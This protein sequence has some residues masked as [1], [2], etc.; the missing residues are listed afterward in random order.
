VLRN[1]N[2]LFVT[3]HSKPDF[4]YG[5]V[6]ESG[7]K[8]F[9]NL[10]EL[11]KI[12]IN[13]ICVSKNP[14]SFNSSFIY[15]SILFHRWG[16]SLNLVIPLFRKIYNSEKIFINGIVTFPTTLALFYSVILKKDFIV[17]IRGGLEPWRI[18]HK[19]WKKYFYFR[20]FVYPFIKYAKLI[21]TT[22]YNEQKSLNNLGFMN[23]FVVTNGIDKNDFIFETTYKKSNKFQFLFLSRTDKE[24]GIDILL[25]AYK[26]FIN[27]YGISN[28]ELLI[29]G[30]DNQNYLKNLNIDFNLKNIIYKDGI[31]SND[32]FQLMKSVDVFILPSY[33]EN[34]GNVIA[35]ALACST[36]VITTTGTP[37]SI[38]NEN[39]CGLCIEPT[40]T[41]LFIA[42]EKLFLLNETELKEMGQKAKNFIFNNF[43][44]ETKA[45][46]ILTKIDQI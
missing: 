36:P 15:K 27:K 25:E 6:V 12:P 34:F 45:Q 14:K 5:G 38:L 43:L 21:H 24:K 31:Y 37:W 41:N 33:S 10:R 32:K 4:H 29:I 30:P 7:S 11:S 28:N 8:L 2:I 42:M 9:S 13:L 16:F 17:S 23:T 3:T 46:E 26:I 1:K 18:N 40:T 20:L 44:W 22:S 35:E 19:K 39:G